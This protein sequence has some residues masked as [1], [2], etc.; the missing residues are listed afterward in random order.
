M[1]HVYV[2]A[3]DTF[4]GG[5]AY[6]SELETYIRANTFYLQRDYEKDERYIHGMWDGRVHL[7]QQQ[8]IGPGWETFNGQF[9]RIPTGLLTRL[10]GL[11]AHAGW[12]VQLYNGV[13]P[14]A[15]NDAV[16]AFDKSILR[17]RDYQTTAVINL[18]TNQ[19]MAAGFVNPRFGGIIQAGTGAGKTVIAAHKI[20]MMRARTVFLV[21]QRE[22]LKQTAKSFKKLLGCPIGIVGDSKCDIQPITVATIQTVAQA[23][24]MHLDPDALLYGVDKVKNYERKQ[25]ICQ[26]M[27]DAEVVFI[28][29]CHTVASDTAFTAVAGAKNA[30][31]IIGLSATPWRD[32]G[33]DLLIE[34]A[35]GPVVFKKSASE[36]IAEGWLVQPDVWVCNLPDPQDKNPARNAEDYAK[37]YDAWVTH[38]EWRHSYIASL[39]NHHTAKGDVVLVLVRRVPH[40]ERLQELIPGSLFMNGE[41]SSKKRD[42]ILDKTRTGEIRCLIATSL[43]DKGLDVPRLNTLILAGGGKS[44]TKA[45]QRI[46]RVLR[47]EN[48]DKAQPHEHA[49]I[50]DLVDKHPLMRRH[51]NTRLGM[52]RTEPMFRIHQHTV[53]LSWNPQ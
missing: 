23:L 19:P 35:C 12:P 42:E 7:F 17:A 29:E 30:V 40:G 37:M 43:A 10:M 27:A 4:I 13:K 15:P 9:H 38:D 22:L 2:Y 32:D 47:P 14:W 33:T 18:M 16:P 24:N 50:Y 1:L 25:A 21:D 45:L 28:D 6:G 51:Y 48:G 52:Y 3:I 49:T 46:G 20:E 34:A 44:S 39:A 41:L 31:S 5:V 11:L 8:T 36:L 53:T 26:M